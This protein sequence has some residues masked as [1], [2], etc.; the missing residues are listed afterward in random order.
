ML[1]T[2]LI[3]TLTV[4]APFWFLVENDAELIIPEALLFDGICELEN[5]PTCAVCTVCRGTDR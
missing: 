4:K 2:W 3:H 5:E 1:A